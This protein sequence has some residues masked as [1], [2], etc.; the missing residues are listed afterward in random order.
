MACK[1]EKIL[2]ADGYPLH[3]CFI[4]SAGSQPPADTDIIA[5]VNL[6]IPFFQDMDT[7]R[8]AVVQEPIA[9][10]GRATLLWLIRP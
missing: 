3:R 4:N 1:I 8:L 9:K 5:F 6:H 7:D 10:P 2:A